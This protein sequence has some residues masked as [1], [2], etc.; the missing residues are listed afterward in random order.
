MMPQSEQILRRKF[1]IDGEVRAVTPYRMLQDCSR[2]GTAGAEDIREEGQVV[3]ETLDLLPSN[4]VF[5][6]GRIQDY[7]ALTMS[8]AGFKRAV[9][10]VFAD[11]FTAGKVAKA[12]IDAIWMC[13]NF[14]LE[15]LDLKAEW[16]WNTGPVGNLAALYAS[17]ESATSYIDALGLYLDEY[18]FAE[19]PGGRC[20]VGFKAVDAGH[21]KLGKK[22]RCPSTLG[23]D[24]SSWII[25]IPFDTCDYR[26][27][28]SVLSEET[29]ARSSL[30]PDISDADYFIDCFE[31]VRELV[32]DGI[33]LSGAT[34]C[35]GGFLTALKGMCRKGTGA[36]IDITSI[37][38]ARGELPVRILFA[39]VPG[40]LIQVSDLDF[41][42]VD[43][44]LILQDIAYFPIGHPV[45]G[46]D[47]S[48]SVNFDAKSGVA[49]IL[50]SLLSGQA[51][52]GED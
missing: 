1:I 36:A 34:V 17:I 29:G 13:G 18:S 48:I 37:R 14:T 5:D 33:V 9:P 31:V 11:S 20:L 42:Y 32:E 27:G 22:R 12:L 38:D 23:A 47:D 15:D 35:D 51:S 49:G 2:D 7:L 19:N 6:S 16:K 4:F 41:D 43:A 39:E 50:Q 25:Y 26:L 8:R 45:C 46:A 52:E 21:P 3:D 10:P 24:P 44:E 30:G 40:V 28:G